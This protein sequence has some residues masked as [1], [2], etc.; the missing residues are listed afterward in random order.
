MARQDYRSTIAKTKIPTLLVTA[1]QS[2]F[3]RGEYA[4]VA[5]DNPAV[6]HVAIDQSG[7]VIMVEQADTFNQVVEDFLKNL[8]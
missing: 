5:K 8:K 4:Q 6:S 2:P 3:Y 1:N 7:H